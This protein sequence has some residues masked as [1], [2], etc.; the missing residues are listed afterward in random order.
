M[1]VILITPPLVDAPQNF[2][3]ATTLPLGVAYLA[4]YLRSKK[5]G[6]KIVDCF[7]EAPTKRSPYKNKYVCIGLTP[8]EVLDRIPKDVDLIGISVMTAISHNVSLEIINA[9]KKKYPK[10]PIVVGGNHA[11]F[12]HKD[13]LAKGIDYVVLGEGELALYELTKVINGKYDP[14]KIDGIAFY[15]GKKLVV[16]PK[17]NFIKDLD[18]LPLPARD[19]MPLK[20]YWKF[21]QAQGPT[22]GKF[23]TLMSARGCPF[24]CKF[25]SSPKFWQRKWRPRSAKNVVDEIEYCVKEFGVTDI[26]F[27]DDGFTT[28]KNRT[29]E[30]CKEIINRD[31]KIKWSL[32]NGLRADTL[33][34]E[35]LEWMKKAGCQYFLV[36]PESGSEYV[37]NLMSKPIKLKHMKQVVR[38]ANKLQMGIGAFFVIGFPG[39]RRRDLAK[40]YSYVLQLM[41]N[42]LD[43]FGMCTFTP[44]P[45]NTVG[46]QYEL[47][48]DFEDWEKLWVSSGVDHKDSKKL[49]TFKVMTYASFYLTQLIRH[50]RKIGRIVVNTALSRQTRKADM[51]VSRK[52][53]YIRDKLKF[54]SL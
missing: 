34:E 7:G 46:P 32:P 26:H 42:G 17:K 13:F 49:N 16:N 33:D 23:V 29:I 41:W 44:L 6:V 43:E 39:E 40:T 4:G 14:S 3:S 35:T 31:L 24:S 20:N 5:I 50:P 2:G 11:T 8:K 45:G 1:K 12:R 22:F 18:A 27:E 51:V 37:L 30:I 10:V 9:I 48:D 54:F 38:K 19:L 36:A 25:C 28:L 52:I 21:K 15:K 47:P 53:K